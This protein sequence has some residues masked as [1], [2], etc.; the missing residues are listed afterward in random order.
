M[1]GTPA[2]PS[3]DGQVVD[4]VIRVCLSW[5]TRM[6]GVFG[7]WTSR[8]ALRMN[9]AT[10]NGCDSMATWMACRVIDVAFIRSANIAW[11]VGDTTRSWPAITNQH[12]LLRQAGAVI[13]AP[14][15]ASAVGPWVA[16]STVCS[17]SD[18]SGAKSSR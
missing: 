2:Q 5:Q 7:H 18:K 3:A 8:A 10:T 13:G 6:T 15:A 14:R 17:E 11:S 1:V 9:D 12:G 4:A 16:A